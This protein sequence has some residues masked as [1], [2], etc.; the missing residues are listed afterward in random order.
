MK[1]LIVIVLSLI[2]TSSLFAQ[3]VKY[4]V[5]PEDKLQYQLDYTKHCLN[6]FRK[7]QL[8]G[9]SI[10]LGGAL[11]II[12]TQLNSVNGTKKAEIN[13]WDNMSMSG[14]SLEGTVF[15]FRQYEMA[16]EDANKIRNIGAIVGGATFIAGAAIQLLGYKWLKRAYIGSD[17]VGVVFK[18]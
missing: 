18:F 3:Y 12:V 2:M 15:A 13:Y 8:T 17:G 9:A 11:M 4:D 16:L 5:K 6:Q 14:N 7:K 10:E 1:K